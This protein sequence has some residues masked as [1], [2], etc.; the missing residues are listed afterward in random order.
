MTNIITD[1]IQRVYVC[2]K[3][4]TYQNK[5]K[6]QNIVNEKQDK[7]RHQSNKPIKDNLANELIHK[8][9]IRN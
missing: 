6:K 1:E 3:I 8:I 9:E 7:N 2:L 5:T 4:I